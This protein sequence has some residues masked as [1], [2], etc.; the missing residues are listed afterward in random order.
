MS[1][2]AVTLVLM[3]AHPSMPWYESTN[4]EVQRCVG[5]NILGVDLLCWCLQV[6]WGLPLPATY[7][8]MLLS[9][10]LHF[11]GLMSEP[12]QAQRPPESNAVQVNDTPHGT[13]L[14]L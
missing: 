8:R 12:R 3:K 5:L 10:V 1:V 7:H 6:G 14:H 11:K 9:G 13:L 2:A 4:S